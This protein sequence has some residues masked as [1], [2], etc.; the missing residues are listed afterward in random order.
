MTGIVSN[1]KHFF[2]SHFDGEKFVV[3]FWQV[4][5]SQM[6]ST[7]EKVLLPEGLIV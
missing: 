3:F 6:Y 5:V 7:G 4:L 1:P 2:T